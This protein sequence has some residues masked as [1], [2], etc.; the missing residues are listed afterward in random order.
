[1]HKMISLKPKYMFRL[2][3]IYICGK[4]KSH[5]MLDLEMSLDLISLWRYMTENQTKQDKYILI[6]GDSIYYLLKTL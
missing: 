3:W 4:G 6:H 5:N 1:M 2:A